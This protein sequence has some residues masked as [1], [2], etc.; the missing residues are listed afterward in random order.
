[1]RRPLFLQILNAIEDYDSYFAQKRDRAGHLGLSPSQKVT[2]VM[3][4]I[5][6]G[7]AA[8]A[9]DDYVQIGETTSIE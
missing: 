6:Y 5:A 4:M 9:I 8:D 2:V 1:M 3:R 7:V